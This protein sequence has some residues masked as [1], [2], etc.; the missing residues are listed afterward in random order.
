MCDFFYFFRFI[1]FQITFVTNKGVCFELLQYVKFDSPDGA[2]CDFWFLEKPE[3]VPIPK[4]LNFEISVEDE[5]ELQ[6]IGEGKRR[7]VLKRFS[8]AEAFSDQI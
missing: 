8:T 1:L 6:N 5:N 7:K 3:N 4:W 2:D